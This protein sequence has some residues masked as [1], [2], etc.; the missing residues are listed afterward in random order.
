MLCKPTDTRQY[1]DNRSCHPKHVKLGIPYGQALRNRRICKSDEVFE[2]RLS[3]LWKDFVKRGFTRNIIDSQFR[4]AKEKS[5]DSLLS[6]KKRGRLI[7][8]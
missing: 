6:Q 3:A 5:R 7:K 4:R 1:L 8:E 2:R